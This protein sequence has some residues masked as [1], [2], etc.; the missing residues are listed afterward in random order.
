MKGNPTRTFNDNEMKNHSIVLRIVIFLKISC[1][2][3]TTHS[4]IHTDASLIGC[5]MAWWNRNRNRVH[6]IILTKFANTTPI[7]AI[8]NIRSLSWLY[9]VQNTRISNIHSRKI[10]FSMFKL[11]PSNNEGNWIAFVKL[12]CETICRLKRW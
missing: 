3:P 9:Q 6:N 7:L 4:Y 2:T 12:I 10:N 1:N 8:E 11:S 5:D